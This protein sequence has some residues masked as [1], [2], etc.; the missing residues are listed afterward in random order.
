MYFNYTRKR[1]LTEN[2]I[3]SGKKKKTLQGA[4]NELCEG[5]KGGAELNLESKVENCYHGSAT[6][7]DICKYLLICT[8]FT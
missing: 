8:L 2:K 3:S 5:E 4:L 1:I 7:L 6:S